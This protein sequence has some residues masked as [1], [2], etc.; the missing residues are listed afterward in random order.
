MERTAKSIYWLNNH[1]SNRK[2][3]TEYKNNLNEHG[4]NSFN[5]NKM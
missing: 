3:Y 1:F 5:A 2:E 4:K